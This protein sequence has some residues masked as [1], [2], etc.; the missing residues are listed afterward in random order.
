V[1]VVSDTGEDPLGRYGKRWGVEALFGYLKS[2]GFDLEATHVTAP[3]R[4]ECLIAVLALAFTWAYACGA[5]LFAHKPWKVKKHGR[6][7]VSVFRGG[8]DFLR[9]LL[10][11]LCGNNSQ[12]EREKVVQILLCT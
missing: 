2:C 12:Q 3:N 6:L 9:R 11:P 1:I 8:L 10:L 5:W 4:L 7:M